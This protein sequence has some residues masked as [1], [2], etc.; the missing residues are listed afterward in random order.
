MGSELVQP[1][2]TLKDYMTIPEAA[3]F[4]NKCS[5]TVNVLIRTGV[6]SARRFKGQGRRLWIKKSDL[7]SY[8]AVEKEGL[9]HTDIRSVLVGLKTKLR[10]IEH[11]L[12][13]LMHTNG[14]DVSILRDAPLATLHDIYMDVVREL[15]EVSPS[16]PMDEIRDWA[17][18]FLQFTEIEFDRMIGPTRDSSPW[19]PFHSLC[20]FLMGSLRRRKGFGTNQDMQQTYR[21]L[22]KARKSLD[23]AIVVFIE[24]HASRVGSVKTR[25]LFPFGLSGDS[26]DR[27]IASEVAD[28]NRLK[29]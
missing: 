5:K 8:K 22:D 3:Q 11:K 24:T 2:L 9:G 7:V 6:L 1:V 15:K 28:H 20:M 17:Y 25:Q 14:L 13:F 4:L 26:L 21:L 23:Q 29:N 16:P 12:D 18:T 19:K 10:S 27:Y